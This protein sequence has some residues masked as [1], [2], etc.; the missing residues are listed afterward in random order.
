MGV[1]FAL[2]LGQTAGRGAGRMLRK[3]IRT[4]GQ[5]VLY[6]LISKMFGNRAEKCA[7]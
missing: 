3:E 6:I 2:E 4:S 1:G 5:S 7:A